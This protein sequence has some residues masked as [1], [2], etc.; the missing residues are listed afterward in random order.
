MKGKVF[1]FVIILLNLLITQGFAV[2]PFNGCPDFM[3]ISASY[4]ET[5]VG[6][7][8]NPFEKDSFASERHNLIVEQGVDQNTGGKLSFI[9]NGE[10]KS[11]RIGND[12]IGGESEALVYH[13][14][15]D[16]ENTLL[17]VNF[18]VVSVPQLVNTS[19]AWW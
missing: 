14:T 7:T 3:D 9:P 16:P 2:V 13:F 4:V 15:V 17:F 19:S 12:D 18:A 1:A 8:D 5:Y 10:V 11:V 6:E